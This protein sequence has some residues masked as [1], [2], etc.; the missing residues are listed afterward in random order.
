MA[1]ALLLYGV[2]AG[3][4][5]ATAITVHLVFRSGAFVSTAEIDTPPDP[6]FEPPS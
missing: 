4:L 2:A 1:P 5:L 3:I 6:P